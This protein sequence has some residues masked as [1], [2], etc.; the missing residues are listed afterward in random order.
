MPERTFFLKP[1]PPLRAF[2]VAAL[3]SLVGGI[4][5]LVGLQQGWPWLVNVLTAVV[6]VAGVGLFAAALVATARLGVR[7]VI[8]DEGYRITGTHQSHEGEWADVTK[9]TQAVTGAH[10][11]IYHGNVR[12]THLIFPGGPAQSR[13]QDVADEIM[14]RLERLK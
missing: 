7:V 9:V 8:S 11:T 5:L 6:L 13:M 14:A 3:C 1:R 2:L 10:L 12:R 4:L